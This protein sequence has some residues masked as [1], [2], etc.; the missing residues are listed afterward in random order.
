MDEGKY[1]FLLENSGDI[2]W[3]IDLSGRW[4]FMTR[5]VERILHYRLENILGK[6]IWGFVA[7][8]YHPVVKEMLMRR[9]RGEDVPSYEV[10]VIDADGSRVP[11][12][13]KTSP[14]RDR[15]GRVIG[16]QG[17]S[18]EISDR[19]QAERAIRKSEEKFRELVEN[20][21]DWVWE[22][23]MDLVITYSNPRVRDYLGYAPEEVTGRSLYDFMEPAYARRIRARLASMVR[24]RRQYEVAEKTLISKGGERVPFEMTLSLIIAE[25]GAIKGFRGICRDIRDRKRAEEASRRAYEELEKRVEERT[26]EL[27]EAKAQAELYLDLMSHD[28]NNMNQVALGN[29]EMLKQAGLCSEKGIAML[30]GALEML[31]SSSQLIANLRKIQKAESRELETQ[32]VD[33]CSVLKEMTRKFSGMPGKDV[34]IDIRHINNDSCKVMANNLIADIFGNLID[35]AIKH[36]IPGRPVRIG[37]MLSKML[38]SGRE[39]LQVAIEDNGPGIP[40]D[41]KSQLFSRLQRGRTATA[42]RGLGLYLVKS[43][44]EHFNGMVWAEDRVPGDSSKGT[45]FVVLLPAADNPS[46]AAIAGMPG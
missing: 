15:E 44:V 43:L 6:T 7:P 20:T 35:N 3:T 4:Q 12:E 1:R 23:D 26:R 27:A 18:R 41:L 39:F 38:V 22:S 37:I 24:L 33:A 11:F 5:N 30:D 21:Y 34:A 42:G 29:L 13:V 36:A 14:I 9:A 10:E 28:I 40:D 17:I 19:K 8:E 31:T 2:L 32:I 46:P 45:R 16:V 25:D